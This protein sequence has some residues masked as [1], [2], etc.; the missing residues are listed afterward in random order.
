MKVIKIY[1]YTLLTLTF[2]SCDSNSSES[3]QKDRKDSI[4]YILPSTDTTKFKDL[5]DQ[6]TKPLPRINDTL[7]DLAHFISGNANSTKYFK[8]FRNNTSYTDFAAR[9]SKR[10]VNFDSTKLLP[11]KNFVS[12]EFVNESKIKNLFYPFSGPDILYANT[13]FPAADVYTMIGLEPVGTLPIVDDKKIVA[14]SIQKYVDKINSSLN[15]ILKFSFF[16]TVS[17]K[18]DLRNDEVDGTIHLLLLFLN[19]TGHQIADVKPFY[20]D[21]T[22][23][24][25]YLESTTVLSKSSYKNKSIEI[26]AIDKNG[27]LK[28]VTYTSTDLSD[29]AL[30]KNKG[31]ITYI[32][33]LH[34]ETTYLKGASYLMHLSA[35]A[36]IR[37]LIL[38]NTKNIVQD[39]S[40]IALHYITTDK[41]KWKFT[42]YG[43]YTKP[44]NMFAKHYQADLDSLYKT[45]GAKKL[46]FGLGYNYRDK[47]SSF[48]LIKKT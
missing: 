37:E 44:I 42:F 10:W 48:M 21:T 17:M 3:K 24:K 40:G 5:A 7:N 39:D 1:F 33:N 18:E 15:A 45:Q 2:I 20:I 41:N 35:F 34:F 29:P 12:Y 16:R 13:I 22:G 26:T 32:N 27:K 47:N 30:R 23:A 14:D 9:F 25:N 46:G 31:L 38:A 36:K 28:T 43:A 4:E 6:N 19:K 8:D 11:I